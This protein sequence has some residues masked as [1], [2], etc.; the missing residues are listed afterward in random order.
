MTHD[1]DALLRPR[2]IAIIGASDDPTRIGGRPLAYLK[3]RGFAG[4][5]WP[6]NP[7]RARVQ[8]LPAFADTAA[9]PAAP[10]AAIIAIPG[11]AAIA[12][13]GALAARG[14]RA[15]I[16]FTAG[17]A[18]TGPEGAAM[19]ARLV[20]AARGHGMRLV[21]PNCLGLFNAALG[22]FPIFSASFEN[23]WPLPGRV[24]IA[25]QSGAY[26]SHLFAAAR[27][28]GIGT[29]VLVTTG[30]EADLHLAD[31][32]EWMAAAEEVEVIAAYAE[33]IR[34]GA[35]F[36]AALE[37]ARRARKPVVLMKVGRS[38]V[39][40]QAAQSHTA[41]IA[42]D[43]R[44]M[45][46][47]LGDLGVHRARTTEELLDVCYVAQKRI[48]PARNTL[49]VVTISGGAG[50]LIA[51]A[52]EA[53]GLPMPPMP[54]DAQ[55]RLKALVPFASPANPVDCTAQAFND[56]RVVGQFA[57]SMAA[58]GGYS[59]L[60]AFF[61]QWGASPS[62]APR[63]R[64]ELKQ[65]LDRHPDRL[66]LLSILAPTD[67]IREWEAD[68]F[69]VMEDP[70]RA[71]V[72]LAAM[73]RFGAAFAAAPAPAPALPAVS[74]PDAAPDEAEA[75]RLLAAAGI[76]VV[77]ERA[78]TTAEEAAQAAREL[79]FPVV[80]KILSPDIL[81]KSEIGGVLLDLADE[82]AVRAG[83]ATLMDRAARHAPAARVTGVLVARQVTGAVEM[84]VGVT[85]DPIFGPVVMAGLGGVFVEVFRDVA[86]ARCPVD[87]AKALA[88]IRTL[89]G[90][91][92]LD[93]A[94][95][96]PRA[97]VAAL[98]RAVVALSRFGAAAPRLLSAEINPLLVLPE[99][100]GA[101]AADAVIETA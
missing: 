101:F 43:D 88:M 49:G 70:S 90:F 65:V 47:V 56:M 31:F 12:A 46:A 87:E 41:S 35:R 76:P 97:D 83:F 67:R 52:A 44:V 40:A 74:L 36:V 6:V 92:L 99:G 11:E 48:Y 20:A 42:G 91:P 32:I 19:Q 53:A 62:M 66:F 2:S 13:V 84:V 14:C 82:A 27:D 68:G 95:G 94:R 57:E 26:G 39:G 72:A 89:R 55:A 24:G 28:R 59:S 29:P 3:Q 7:N 38:A 100:Q 17:F 5:I 15:G 77:P 45:D 22:H 16:V 60:I 71:V 8:D 50:V 93:G 23:G 21:G 64:A 58:E 85:R 9:L 34:D 18:E 96:R 73:G 80:A 81:H 54:E 33:G 30:N 86:F 63:L 25:S 1:L 79:G 78:C 98:A 61:T 4:A 37:A 10:D 69:L 51:D 75:K